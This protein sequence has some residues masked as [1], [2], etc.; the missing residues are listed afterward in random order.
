[1]T[2]THGFSQLI[3][4]KIDS[5]EGYFVPVQSIRTA[6]KKFAQLDKFIQQQVINDSISSVINIKLGAVQ[7]QFSNALEIARVERQK[8][9]ILSNENSSLRIVIKEGETNLKQA[10]RSATLLRLGYIPVVV[11]LIL[12]L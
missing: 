3:Q 12:L 4:L 7:K 1:M 11:V 9:Q 5:V 10:K 6:N 2:S 8:N